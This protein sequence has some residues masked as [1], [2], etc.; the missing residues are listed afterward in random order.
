MDST[1]KVPVPQG[2]GA[3]GLALQHGDPGGPQPGGVPLPP[4]LGAHPIE[5]AVVPAA[6][7]IPPGLQEA[8][9]HMGQ[10]CP[11]SPPSRP[12]QGRS[13]G[14]SINEQPQA[15]HQGLEGAGTWRQQHTW[16]TYIFSTDGIFNRLFRGLCMK[17]LWA[18][19]GS[20]RC[21]TKPPSPETGPAAQPRL[22][23]RLK[24]TGRG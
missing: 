23:E 13:S 12:T 20:G 5:Q 8:P 11:T 10:P 15:P 21:I 1:C 9:R 16:V 14:R 18:L 2:G 7:H 24:G 17:N 6:L 22:L 3:P 19:A 4:L